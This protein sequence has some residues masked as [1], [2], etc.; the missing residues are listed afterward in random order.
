MKILRG[1]KVRVIKVRKHQI[2]KLSF[3]LLNVAPLATKPMIL[4][5]THMIFKQA[6]M[7]V[8]WGSKLSQEVSVDNK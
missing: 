2:R 3:Y 5:T 6:V 7:K 8:V 4:H 1:L